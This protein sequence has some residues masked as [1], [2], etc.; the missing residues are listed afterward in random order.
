MGPRGPILEKEDHPN[1]V[2]ITSGLVTCVT[3]GGLGEGEKCC[4]P[5]DYVPETLAAP[6]MCKAWSAQHTA[7]AYDILAILLTR[8]FKPHLVYFLGVASIF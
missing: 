2:S 5:T 3:S 6:Q 1:H 8:L 4:M 7:N